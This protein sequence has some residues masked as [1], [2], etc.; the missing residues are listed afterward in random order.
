MTTYRRCKACKAPRP[1]LTCWKCGEETFAPCAGWEEQATPDIAQIKALGYEKGYNMIVHGS[2][3]RD[4]DIVAVPWTEEAIGNKDL[5]DHLC[6]GLNA[7]VVD[8]TRKPHGRYAFNL[9]ID[10]YYKLI[11]LSIMPLVR[12]E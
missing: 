9:Q 2:L 11:D 3:E 6:A 7:K 10:G 1:G 12:K 8:M 4:L 5:V